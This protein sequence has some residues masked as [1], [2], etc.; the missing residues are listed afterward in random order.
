M[1]K[2][3]F[4]NRLSPL[5]VLPN[6]DGKKFRFSVSERSLKLIFNYLVREHNKQLEADH[7]VNTY[8]IALIQELNDLL[9]MIA[10]DNLTESHVVRLKGEL[11]YTG[12]FINP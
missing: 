4:T 5:F 12:S 1:Q 11:K 9:T 8:R 6:D 3:D 10:N 7:S 2:L